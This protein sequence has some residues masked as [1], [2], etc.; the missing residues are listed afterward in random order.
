MGESAVNPTV[1][2]F[3]AFELDR[4]RRELRK[5]GV[6]IKLQEQPFQILSLLL[7][8]PGEIVAREELQKRLWPENT[9]VDFDL[10]LN[11]AVKK[12]RQSLNDDPENPRYV[13]TLYRRGYRF[14][15]PVEELPKPELVKAVEPVIEQ[16]AGTETRRFASKVLVILAA[17]VLIAV[18]LAIWLLVP[19]R[20]PRVL[21]YTQITHDGR[22]KGGMVSDGERLYFQELEGDHFVVAEVSANGGETAI[23]PIPFENV[24]VS[25]TAPD[26]SALLIASFK[27]ATVKGEE[28]GIWTV[29][30]PVGAPRR[31]GDLG[32]QP[33]SWTPD[34]REVIFSRDSAI[35]RANSDGSGVTKLAAVHGNAQAFRFS[36]N[37]RTM[38]F[39][40][41]DPRT[42]ANDIWEMNSDGSGLRQLLKNWGD[43][44]DC[45]G[46]WTPDG[47]YYLFA[48]LREGTNNLWL[49]PAESHWY[50]GQPRPVQ[51]TNGPLQFG[52]PVPSK[53]G[54]RI[55]SL[56]VQPRV[57]L[58]QLNR[59][60]SLTP[61]AGNRS[62]TDL[63]FSVDGEWVAYVAVPENTLWRSR[64]DGSEPLQLTS[65]STYAALPRWSPDGKR[66]TFMGRPSN[67]SYHA[68]VIASNGGTP[69]PLVPGADGGA[70]PGWSPDGESIVVTLGVTSDTTGSGI[71]I[72]NLTTGKIKLLPDSENYFSPRWSPDG[73]YIA[74]ITLDSTKMVLF[75]TVTEKWSDLASNGPIGFPSWS[76][77][78]QY[79][80]YDT[81]LTGDPGLYRVQVSTQ[82]VDK[83]RSL[84]DVRRPRGEFGPWVG[85]AP[86]DS[87]LLVRDISSQEIYA[88]EWEAP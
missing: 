84:K 53:D 49:L 64:V 61:Y 51:L 67:G 71:S 59:D 41:N 83:L 22:P 76:H 32:P 75:D 2:R 80:Y 17:V 72:V 52:Y 87:P 29:P 3:G 74:A 60:G 78:S 21:G 55:F 48:S 39:D 40:L 79:L 11:S 88:L 12:L 68:Y 16:P 20:P 81:T 15:G 82:K 37:G 23:L 10:S 54:K 63:A 25:D 5:S 47:K 9:Y 8:R 45:C 35:Y 86:D 4:E 44:L 34:G 69:Q 7:E 65:S 85:L 62:A 43:A 73:K 24:I 50:S 19:R 33:A 13:E 56:G 46:N 14:I 57:E 1:V 18:T 77:D 31:I 26:G 66:I 42:G 6:K 28:S 58:L 30:L 27:G 36:P 38:R 70:D